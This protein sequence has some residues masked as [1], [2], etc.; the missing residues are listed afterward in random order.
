MRDPRASAAF[1]QRQLISR[2]PLGALQ[3]GRCSQSQL[4]L[5]ASEG[6]QISKLLSPA[7]KRGR[8]GEVFHPQGVSG[9]SKLYQEIFLG[10][11]IP[12]VSGLREAVL[13]LQ[14]WEAS[15][16]AGGA[17]EPGCFSRTHSLWATSDAAHNARQPSSR[18]SL[19]TAAVV[20]V[21]SAYLACGSPGWRLTE[22]PR[23]F[24][25]SC[26]SIHP[27]VPWPL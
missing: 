12:S 9:I 26:P 21:A 5:P 13:R 19:P 8:S 10:I 18:L 16:R 6:W 3:R 7:R 14:G 4:S 27:S 2:L 1:V 15:R 11:Y 23:R 25:W 20:M 22:P 17:A 24:T